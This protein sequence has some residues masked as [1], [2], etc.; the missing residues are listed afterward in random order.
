PA[1]F[2]VNRC[3]MGRSLRTRVPRASVISPALNDPSAESELRKLRPHIASPDFVLTHFA[4]IAI[5]ATVIDK[6][7]LMD[8]V[9][10]VDPEQ[11]Q[12]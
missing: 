5:A 9:D 7:Y 3:R 11:W 1:R 4:K 2:G 8:D 6:F 10:T 12:K